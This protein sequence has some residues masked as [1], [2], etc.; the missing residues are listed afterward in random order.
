MITFTDF[1]K[2]L[3]TGQLKNTAAVEEANMGE[4]APDFVQ[5]ILDRTNEGL[6]DLSTR[7]A[8]IN[9]E[10]DLVFVPGQHIYQLDDIAL[11]TYLDNSQT[12]DFVSSDFVRILDVFDK[13]GKPHA[14]DTQGHIMTP[15]YNTLRFSTSK[16]NDI[17]PRIRI[18]YQAKHPH[19]D[20]DGVI[21]IPPNLETALQLF[22]ASLYLSHMGG[23]EHSKKGDSYFGAYLRHIGED[24][25]RNTSS[26]SEVDVD[27]RF[28]DRGFV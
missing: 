25:T 1:A 9:R 21:T 10:V 17:G 6:V 28:A 3:A 11:T 27:T 24:E 22:V 4:I 14:H 8:L 23:D 19:I 15:T 2:R 16:M 5:T 26:T 13:D 12:G 20:E 18:R 7:F